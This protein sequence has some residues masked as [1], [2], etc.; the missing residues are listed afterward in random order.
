MELPRLKIPPRL[1]ERMAYDKMAG[2]TPRMLVLEGGYWLDAACVK[3]A[4]TLGWEVASAPV[5]MEGTLPR[6]SIEG[7]LTMLVALRPDFILSINLAGMD[8]RGVFARLFEDLAIPY[9]AWFVDDPRTI[10]MG[11]STFATANAVALTWERAYEEYLRSVGFPVTAYVPLAVDPSLFDGDPAAVCEL[12]PAFVGNSMA[13]VADSERRGVAEHPALAR[14]LDDAFA[15]GRVTRGNFGQ[16]LDAL[17]DASVLDGLDAEQRRHAEIVFFVEGTRR[18]REALV[19]QLE[20]EG[21]GVHGDAGWLGVTPNVQ[22]PVDYT[23]GLPAFYRSCE[24]NVNS[25]SI[26]MPTAVNQR[27]FDCP[28]AGGFLLT[29][30]QADL[31]TLFDVARETARYD[32]LEQCAALLRDYRRNPAARREVTVRARKRILGE[33]TYAHRLQQIATMVKEHWGT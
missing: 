21:L 23:N 33:H 13:H 5:K 4:R 9:V 2:G 30:A 3:A 10:L 32:S 31:E 22:P 16:G 17:L 14:A 18:L 24:V 12:P 20:P 19:R 8:E 6:E 29:D 15:A 28:A 11:R 1:C 25:T 26:Q 7:L 27:V